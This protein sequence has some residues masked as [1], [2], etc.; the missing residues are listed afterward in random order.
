MLRSPYVAQRKAMTIRV[1]ET[2]RRKAYSYYRPASRVSVSAAVIRD[3][4]L[5][6]KGPQVIP[7]RR[8][9][10]L[11]KFGYAVKASPTKR[12][13]ALTA[14]ILRGRTSPLA[15]FRRLQAI[16]TLSK[17]SMPMYARVYLKNRDWVRTKFFRR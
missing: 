17:R 8:T 6:G 5:P 11:S 15:V 1:G 14:A 9:G 2:P 16:A 10:A 12:H 7:I 3:L 4:G 13:R